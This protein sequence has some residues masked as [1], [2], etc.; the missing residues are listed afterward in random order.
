MFYDIRSPCQTLIVHSA[1]HTVNSAFNN[2]LHW[3]NL[4][5]LYKPADPQINVRNR[6]DFEKYTI[7]SIYTWALCH[8][9]PKVMHAY[10]LANLL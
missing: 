8:P 9:S 4:G 3:V 10:I 5:Y 6:K 1:C 7:Q 2:Y